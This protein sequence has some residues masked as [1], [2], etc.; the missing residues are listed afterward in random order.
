MYSMIQVA[1]TNYHAHYLSEIE[2]TKKTSFSEQSEI[3]KL[4]EEMRLKDEKLQRLEK[5][6][7]SLT[8]GMTIFRDVEIL[9]DCQT[10]LTL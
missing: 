4:K 2:V 7:S 1:T 3:E 6:V 10:F 5:Q 9:S 8:S